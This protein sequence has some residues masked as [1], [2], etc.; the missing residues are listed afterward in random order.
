ME[1][2]NG[3]VLLDHVIPN[4]Q[5]ALKN[6][7]VVPNNLCGP[8]Y[9]GYWI[10]GIEEK[11]WFLK[12]SKK[13][14][15]DSSFY[16]ELWMEELARNVSIPSIQSKIVK[17]GKNVYG[18]VSESYLASGYDIVTGEYIIRTYQEKLLNKRDQKNEKDLNS[19][20]NDYQGEISSLE[21]IWEALEDYFNDY[22]NKRYILFGILRGLTERYI[23]SFLTLNRDFH[24]GNWE[25]LVSPTHA[26]LTPLYDMDLSLDKN[27][28]MRHNSM[29]ATMKDVS[30]YEDFMEFYWLSS[31][32]FKKELERQFSILTPE[33]LK[34]SLENVIKEHG[35]FM[36]V[37]EKQKLLE[38]YDNHFEKITSMLER[39]KTL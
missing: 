36:D 19:M 35:I 37:R 16:I 33:F 25:L 10:R 13:N 14:G 9:N 12:I 30:I 5:K 32:Y 31:P 8:F 4:W 22:S 38:I 34:V 27:Y 39:R 6:H 24:A 7:I 17:C 15:L 18:L 20:L 21:F 29:R 1:Q 3:I 2:E 28:E 23:F 11:N 26:V